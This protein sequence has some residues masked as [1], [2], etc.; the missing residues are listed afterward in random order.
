MCAGQV[1]RV[2]SPRRDV[3]APP[4]SVGT[5][6]GMTS[7]GAG[8][9][10]AVLKAFD[11]PE[12]GWALPGGEGR[13]F[14]HGGVVLK[15]VE[16]VV[17]AT[18]SAQVMADVEPRD[19]R[20]PRPLRA[21]DG[22]W[23]VNGWAAVEHVAG[24]TGPAGRWDELLHMGREFHAALAHIPRP[25]FLDARTHRWARADRVA[26]GEQRVEIPDEAAEHWAR[27]KRLVRLVAAPAQLIHGDLSGNVLFADG[28]EPAVIDFSPYWRPVGYAD[29]IVVVDGML[30][31]GA[32]SEL[33]ASGGLGAVEFPQ[34][35]VRALIFRLV[36]LTEKSR[37]LDPACLSELQLFT[38]VIS[39]VEHAVAQ[40]S[41]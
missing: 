16:N 18:W 13:S 33:M 24:E 2:M 3:V 35:L 34:M 25:E 6:I 20:L 10:A 5:I 22:R 31:F 26:W 17:E 21:R 32:G 41:V 19:F 38:P 12:P 15:P 28:T 7:S 30:W 23:V 36:A 40:R 37:E 4:T 39:A 27:L 9:P 29:A 1:L 14:L 11:L 8:V